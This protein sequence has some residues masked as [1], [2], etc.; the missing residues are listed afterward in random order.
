MKKP[1]SC[2]TATVHC[3]ACSSAHRCGLLLRPPLR[4][5]ALSSVAT[6]CS[7]HR[8][9]LL[10]CPPLRPALR[11]PAATWCSTSVFCLLLDLRPLF[12]LLLNSRLLG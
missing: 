3:P 12:L 11:P 7:A 4:P 1:F 2:C 10:L 8:C 6:C 9:G 5:G